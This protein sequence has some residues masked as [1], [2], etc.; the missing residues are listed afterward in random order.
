MTTRTTTAAQSSTELGWCAWHKGDA[1][2]V[3]LIHVAYLGPGPDTPVHRSACA[4]CRW[5]YNLVPLAYPAFGGQ[6]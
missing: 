2:G 6:P 4:P 1:E 3:R 5:E